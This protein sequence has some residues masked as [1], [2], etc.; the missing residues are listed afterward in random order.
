MRRFLVIPTF[1]LMFSL[2]ITPFR[3]M[4]KPV[5]PASPATVEVALLAGGCFWGVEDLMRKL[6]GVKETETGYTG[7]FLPNATYDK[8]KKGNSGHAEAVRIVFD[9]AKTSYEKILN[10]F[11]RIHDPTTLNRQGNDIG[12]QYRSAIFYL[13][14]NQ[15]KIAEKVR[16]KVDATGFWKGKV[17]TEIVPAG[18]FYRAEDF[19][20][21]YLE[22]NPG[23]YTCHYE[24]PFIFGK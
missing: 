18:D 6:P 23:G 21:K 3:A 14:D 17:V 12:S 11:F 19:H 5:A 2:L 1:L 22:K 16:A 7:G 15:R 20:Q 9:P 8:V 24:R 4:A 13:S 10:Y